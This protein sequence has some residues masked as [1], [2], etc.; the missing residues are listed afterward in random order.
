MVGSLTFSPPHPTLL[1]AGTTSTSL[2]TIKKEAVATVMRNPQVQKVNENSN[3]NLK[4][5]NGLR[6]KLKV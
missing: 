2:A 6:K 4:S 3:S 5:L 1:G